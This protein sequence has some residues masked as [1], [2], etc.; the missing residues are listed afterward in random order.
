[1]KKSLWFW[2][3]W[4]GLSVFCTRVSASTSNEVEQLVLANAA[5]QRQALMARYDEVG[6]TVFTG[7]CQQLLEQLQITIFT[8]CGLFNSPSVNA[9]SFADG[10]LYLTVGLI[11]RLKNNHQLAHVIAHEAAHLQLKHHFQEYQQ[12]SQP[13]FFFPKRK[14]KKFYQNI[15]LEADRWAN[16]RLQKHGFDL[17]QIHFFWQAL[18]RQKITSSKHNAY[19][20]LRLDKAQLH[21]KLIVSDDYQTWL[22]QVLQKKSEATR[23]SPD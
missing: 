18:Q 15:E 4:L 20:Q 22:E 8:D 3:G 21:N 23:R 13:S 5:T 16:Q 19:L 17:S 6:G 1:M 7:R 14:L 12:L 11:K 10:H 2:I 9:Y